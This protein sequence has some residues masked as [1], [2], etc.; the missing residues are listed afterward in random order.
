M[1]ATCSAHF[2]LLDMNT[3]NTLMLL[4]MQ[5]SPVSCYFL[6]VGS[7]HRFPLL[8]RKTHSCNYCTMSQT[9]RPRPYFDVKMNI[10]ERIYLPGVTR[11][12]GVKPRNVL[13]SATKRKSYHLLKPDIHLNNTETCSFYLTLNFPHLVTKISRLNIS[14]SYQ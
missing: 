3:R 6:P 1:H 12:C 10:N 7:K 14:F 9:R 8:Y 2:N 4:M 5:F 11:E 13:S